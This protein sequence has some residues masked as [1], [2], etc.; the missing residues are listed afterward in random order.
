[1]SVSWLSHG[2]RGGLH[3]F[4]ASR[5]AE[6]GFVPGILVDAH[7]LVQHFPEKKLSFLPKM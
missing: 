2:L 6:S 4:A 3:S 1:L 5:L 7:I